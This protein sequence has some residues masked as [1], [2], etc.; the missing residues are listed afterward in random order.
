MP[1]PCAIASELVLQPTQRKPNCSFV[2]R[3]TCFAYFLGIYDEKRH[4]IA[5]PVPIA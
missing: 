4:T 1:I 2:M 5:L 3:N